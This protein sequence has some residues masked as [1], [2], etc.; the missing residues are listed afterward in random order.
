MSEGKYLKCSCV[1]C[2]NHIEF[3]Q[4]AVGETVACPHCGQSTELT[5]AA[6]AKRPSRRIGLGM[7]SMIAVL[8]IAGTGA[9]IWVSRQRKQETLPAATAPAAKAAE[10]PAVTPAQPAAQA[11]EQPKKSP[12]DLK[13]GA[14]E[15][16]KTKGSSLVYA[17]GTVKNDSDFQRFGVRIELN[18]MDKKGDRIG[19]AKDYIGI[20]EPRH[21]W[22]FRALIPDSKAV[23]AKVASLKEED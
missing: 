2:G 21:D 4:T 6:Q 7:I 15:L 3:P 5:D 20:L 17:V 23:A 1:H 22:Q 16:E 14:I 12:D 19:T 11:A 13:V 9:G 10:T 8:L 18:L